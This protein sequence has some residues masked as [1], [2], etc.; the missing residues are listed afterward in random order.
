MMTDTARAAVAAAGTTTDASRV[1]WRV[2]GMICLL[3]M[4]TYLDRVNISIAAKSIMETYGLSPVA[5]GQVF[6]A[7]ILAYGLF[8]VPGGWLGD[9][10]GPRIVITLAV[11]WW[12]AFTAATAII[13]DVVPTALVPALWSLVFA[14]FAFGAGEAAAWP[15]FNRTIANWMSPGERAFATSVPLAGGGVGA[16]VTPPLIAWVLVHYGWRESFYVS[17]AVGVAAALA[18][19]AV[20]RDRPE[21]HPGVNAAELAHIQQRTVS[22]SGAPAA[23]AATAASSAPASPRSNAPVATPWR[24]IFSSRNV[25][26]LFFSACTCGYMVYIYMTWFI[27]YLVNERGLTLMQ[28]SLYTTGPFFAMAVLSPLGGALSD[29]IVRRRGL[30]VGRRTISMAGMLVSAVSMLLGT[31]VADIQLAIVWLSLG[32]GAIYFALSAHWATT[33]D[34]S[35]EHA[36]TVSGVMNWGGNMGGMI[37]PILTPMLADSIGWTPALQLA[38]VIIAAGALLWLLVDPERKI[39]HAA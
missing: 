33:I 39:P 14:R 27:T 15:C 34:I 23:A 38:A 28:S 2:L 21:E 8:Q 16:A 3:S 22:P 35:K 9:R 12:S 6:S 31:W 10:F 1:R 25:W 24:A 36:G 26:L 11:I 4:V 20:A 5:M 18:W 7:F 29:A 30:R 19:Y 17:A 37:S 32:A 13:A